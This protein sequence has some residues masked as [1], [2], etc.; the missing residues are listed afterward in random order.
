[1]RSRERHRAEVV[2]RVQRRLGRSRNVFV[3]CQLR[4]R[5]LAVSHAALFPDFLA[6]RK[7]FF[8]ALARCRDIAL[9]QQQI[10]EPAQLVSE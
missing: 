2:L 10:A 4:Q 7:G 8:M 5:K 1:M 3:Q 9:D 6:K